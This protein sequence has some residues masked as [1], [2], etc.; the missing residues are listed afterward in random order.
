MRDACPVRDVRA[1]VCQPLV[2]L[3]IQR[4][5]LPVFELR[6]DVNDGVAIVVS[7]RFV[8]TMKPFAVDLAKTR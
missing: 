7:I 8:V 4:E 6:R 3:D 2:A 1:K 5:V